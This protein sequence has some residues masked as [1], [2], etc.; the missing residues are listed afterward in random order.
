[1]PISSKF[2]TILALYGPITEASK[3]KIYQ[4]QAH[5]RHRVPCKL[6]YYQ[7]KFEIKFSLIW[8]ATGQA[9]I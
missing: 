7:R 4:T 5:L 2:L 1:V 3:I 9:Q 6:N 8:A